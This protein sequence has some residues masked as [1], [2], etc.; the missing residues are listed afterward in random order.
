MGKIKV[1]PAKKSALNLK[2][3]IDGPMTAAGAM[4]EQDGFTFRLL[5]DGAITRDPEKAWK[6]PVEAA[7]SPPAAE[8]APTEPPA[9]PKK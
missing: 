4:W 8:S 6:A 5:T 3:P 9:A 1:L 7:A 2:H